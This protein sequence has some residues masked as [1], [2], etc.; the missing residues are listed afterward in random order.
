[1]L[2]GEEITRAAEIVR[3]TGKLPEGTLFAHIVLDEPDKAAFAAWKPGDPIERNARVLAV[4]RPELAVIEIVVC[5]T[6]GSVREWREEKGMRPALLFT[7]VVNAV[8]TTREHP[9]YVAALA[10][11]GITDL[12]TI[13]IDPWPAGSFGFDAEAGR[14][15]ARCISFV[16][17]DPLDNGYAR[18]IEG[19][20]VH[21]D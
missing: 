8:F 7:E 5:L 3:A 2:T 6:D 16:R 10:R 12:D 21:F 4:P 18:P 14:R 15:I 9:E 17:T 11:R 1:M 19:L 20:I 13:Q